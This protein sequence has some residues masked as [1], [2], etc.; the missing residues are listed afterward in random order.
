MGGRL[1][2]AAPLP[3]RLLTLCFAYELTFVLQANIGLGLG[4]TMALSHNNGTR[5]IKFLIGFVVMEG[6]RIN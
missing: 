5:R 1:L 3:A 6:A 4:E 2:Q